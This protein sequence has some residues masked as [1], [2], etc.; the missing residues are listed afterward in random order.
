MK[1]SL[2]FLAWPLRVKLAALLLLTSLIP[3]TI[4]A[5]VDIRGARERLL[6][7]ATALMSTRGDQLSNRLDAFNRAYQISVESFARLPEGVGFCLAVDIGNEHLNPGVHAAMEVW[8]A[9]DVGIRGVALLD[10]S[11]NHPIE[12]Q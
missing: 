7:D 8:P 2:H 3:L 10:Q 11:G 12:P 5:V 1:I 9:S 6:P 4:P